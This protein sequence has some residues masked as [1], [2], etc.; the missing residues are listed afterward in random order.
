VNDARFFS[1]AMWCCVS[2][3][4]TYGMLCGT[5][6]TPQ[7]IRTVS[8]PQCTAAQNGVMLYEV[9]HVTVI[10]SAR[11]LLS[12]PTRKIALILPRAFAFRFVIV[13]VLISI[14]LARYPSDF[15]HLIPYSKRKQLG[16]H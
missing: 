6:F 16:S 2:L 1:K 4:K 14:S 12:F 11:L 8:L 15:E 7:N 9:C 13:R 10:S 5:F 3:L